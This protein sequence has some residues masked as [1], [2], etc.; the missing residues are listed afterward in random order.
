M[1]KA[2]L[3]CER[4]SDMVPGRRDQRSTSVAV[5]RTCGAESELEEGENRSRTTCPNSKHEQKN[6]YR[7]TYSSPDEYEFDRR[8]STGGMLDARTSACSGLTLDRSCSAC[9][10]ATSSTGLSEGV[11][12]WVEGRCCLAPA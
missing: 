6:H 2:D 8:T 1:L 3:R 7:H 11:F 4:K 10:T 9:S 12:C 5:R